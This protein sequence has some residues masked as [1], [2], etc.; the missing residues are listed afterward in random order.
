MSRRNGDTVELFSCKEKEAKIREEK[1]CYN[2]IPIV[3]SGFVKVENRIFTS[4]SKIIEC[5]IHF[6][7]KVKAKEGWIEINPVIKKITPPQEL[8]STGPIEHLDMAQGGIYTTEE[9]SSWRRH[10]ELGDVHQAI[11]TSIAHGVCI[12]NRMCEATPG[13]NQPQYSLS[14]LQ[15]LPDA[16][17]ISIWSTISQHIRDYGTYISILVLLIEFIRITSFLVM[18]LNTLILDGLLA[19]K[20]LLYLTICNT[21]HQTQKVQRRRKRQKQTKHYEMA[22]SSEEPTD[23]LGPDVT[24]R[25]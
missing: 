24:N 7:L 3:P 12:G 17:E 18:F 1:V 23:H 11:S 15:M 9:L 25:V 22:L 6:P 20:A 5:N 10:L 13:S 8:P 19:A 4:S 14:A 2:A 16:L 21:Y